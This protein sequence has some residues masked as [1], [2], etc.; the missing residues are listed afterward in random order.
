MNEQSGKD[1]FPRRRI[2]N[3]AS[4]LGEPVLYGENKNT[5]NIKWTVR[6]RARRNKGKL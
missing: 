3:S 2:R 6:H 1:V 5:E 4:L